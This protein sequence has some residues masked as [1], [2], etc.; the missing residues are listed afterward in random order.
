MTVAGPLAARGID[1]EPCVGV[2]LQSEG[3]DII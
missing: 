1:E 2:R 3:G